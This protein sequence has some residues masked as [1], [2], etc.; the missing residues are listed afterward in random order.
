MTAAMVRTASPAPPVDAVA[1]AAARA[2]AADVDVVFE[3]LADAGYRNVIL[4]RCADGTWSAT[5]HRR[6]ASWE[7]QPAFGHVASLDGLGRTFTFVAE[8]ATATGAL[9]EALRLARLVPAPDAEGR[10]A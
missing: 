3:E 10:A 4:H 9:A 7:L 5:T 6:M 8:G 2:T 1:A